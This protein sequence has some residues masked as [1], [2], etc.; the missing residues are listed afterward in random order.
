[1]DSIGTDCQFQRLTSF[2]SLDWP[3][4]CRHEP[5]LILL[6]RRARQWRGTTNWR[7]Y[8]ALKLDLSRLAGWHARNPLLRT[9]QAYA[10]AHSAIFGGRRR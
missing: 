9:S 2:N 1:M 3:A 7:C 6:A 10:V 8:E 5:G 4:L